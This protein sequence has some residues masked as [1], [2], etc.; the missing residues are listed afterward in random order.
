MALPFAGLAALG[1]AALKLR[2]SGGNAAGGAGG[3]GGSS[4]LGEVP[5]DKDTR[6]FF[7]YVDAHQVRRLRSRRKRCA[8]PQRARG[9][10]TGEKPA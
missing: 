9:L 5:V 8:A 4:V 1:I 6:A 2:Q 3:G 7:D 10:R